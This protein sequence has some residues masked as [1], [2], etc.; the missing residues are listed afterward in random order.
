MPAISA[1]ELNGRNGACTRGNRCSSTAFGRA[2][3]RYAR[4][5]VADILR[6]RQPVDLPGLAA[7][8]RMYPP[9]N[10]YRRAACPGHRPLTV[11]PGKQ[12]NDGLVADFHRPI[13]RTKAAMIFSIVA[14]ST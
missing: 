3:A 10:R 4:D 7:P 6:Q 9:A 11:E 14:G 12:E 8:A 13:S 5:R 1:D 2:V